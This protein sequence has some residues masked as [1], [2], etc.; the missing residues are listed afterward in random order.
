M[1]VCV[2]V[3]DNGDGKTGKWYGKQR[4]RERRERQKN[5]RVLSL[6]KTEDLANGRECEKWGNM[7]T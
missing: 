1:C 3:L 2:R 5:R 6:E 4:A 7:L